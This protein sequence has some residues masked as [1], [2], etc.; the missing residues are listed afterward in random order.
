MTRKARNSD[1]VPLPLHVG[2][3]TPGV[4]RAVIGR[5]ASD[6]KPGLSPIHSLEIEHADG[7]KMNVERFIPTGYTSAS[8]LQVA[9]AKFTAFEQC[10]ICLSPNPRSREHVPPKGLGGVVLT[11]TCARCNNQFGSTLEADLQD[12]FDDA[13]HV[14]FQSDHI[15]GARRAP[16]LLV[17]QTPEG[18]PVFMLD[19]G[20]V[21]PAIAQM[22]AAG[23][24]ELV[25]IEPDARRYK[26][27][28][29][30]SAYLAACLFLGIVPDSPRATKVRELLLSVRDQP[31]D[32]P[33]PQDP[34]IDEIKIGRSYRPADGRVV[35]CLDPTTAGR[36]WFISMAGTFATPWPLEPLSI[37]ES[38]DPQ[39]ET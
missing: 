5:G 15:R 22:L 38:D 13:V 12:W 25:P 24:F 36:G 29:L 16:R 11:L 7:G 26:L 37:G 14:R 4:I 2:D 19:R 6:S 28:A 39:H 35:L 8:Y 17:R 34:L 1:R 3:K 21:D 23:A 20:T 33:V 27:A 10:P 18:K 9:E 32:A 31:R 30:K